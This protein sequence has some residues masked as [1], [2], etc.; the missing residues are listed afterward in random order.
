MSIFDMFKSKPA[1]QQE[2]DHLNKAIEMLYKNYEKKAVSS[3]YYLKKNAEFLKRKEK[4]EN[5]LHI[6]KY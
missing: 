6:E 4:L 3:E 2:L 1:K 5:E